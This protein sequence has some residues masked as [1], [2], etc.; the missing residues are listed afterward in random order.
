MPP[1]ASAKKL[2]LGDDLLDVA[3]G[4][5][6]DLSTSMEIEVVSSPPTVRRADQG[7]GA[8][9][10]I[11]IRAPRSKTPVRF[12]VEV[13]RTHLS[14]ALVDGVIGR[15]AAT[16]QPWLLCA[17]YVA[18]T[19][20]RYL[21]ERRVGFFDAT[22]NCHLSIG[23]EVFLHHVESRRVESTGASPRAVRAPGYNIVFAILTKPELLEASVREIEQYAHAT[24]STV[25]NQLRRLEAEG[26]LARARGHLRLVRPRDLFE[27]FIAGYADVL[28]PRLFIGRYATPFREPEV[29]EEKIE[30]ELPAGNAGADGRNWWWGGSSAGWRLTKHY[31]SPVTTLHIDELSPDALRRLRALP[32]PTGTLELLR[33]P[34]AA[35][36]DG[37]EG[38]VDVVHPLL[39]YAEMM[40]SSDERTREAAAG[41]REQHLRAFS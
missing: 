7:K 41:L 29:L 2:Q 20:A 37:V 33:I 31:R 3:I 1:L 16:K 40:T 27:K 24:K 11:A 32:S 22:G 36:I 25:S 6:R 9:A 4:R 17:P 21:I 14:Y 18:P 5:L 34:N 15:H 19:M 8:D 10:V 38:H 13:K 12:L 28:R 23:G 39:V 30:M 26:I 35:A